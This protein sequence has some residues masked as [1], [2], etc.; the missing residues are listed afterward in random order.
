[1]VA[2]P[3][4]VFD[5]IGEALR[6]G[7]ASSLVVDAEG[8]DVG[9]RLELREGRVRGEGLVDAE[10]VGHPVVDDVGIRGG[11]VEHLHQGGGAL[12]ARAEQELADDLLTPVRGGAVP[13]LRVE[14]TRVEP[15][16]IEARRR[17]IETH[18]GSH[19]QSAIH[20][21]FE[22][23]RGVWRSA[24]VRASA[25]TEERGGGDAQE[26]GPRTLPRRVRVR[27]HRTCGDRHSLSR[28]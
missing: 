28:R 5:E 7:T 14:E 11:G 16:R 10:D 27:S 24:R 13:D 21:P 17:T 26:G 12:E 2:G 22:A 25:D 3:G 19:R 4:G 8:P 23:G 18:V 9:A 1:M 6:G 15:A 20:T